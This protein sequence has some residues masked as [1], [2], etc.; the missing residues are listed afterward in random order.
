MVFCN[1]D[2][3]TC[4]TRRLHGPDSL[5]RTLSPNGPG[6]IAFYARDLSA[7]AFLAP[8]KHVAKKTW[9]D[10]PGPAGTATAFLAPIKHVAKKTWTDR[11]GPA[12]TI[13][14]FAWS[15][16]LRLCG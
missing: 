8:I 14:C 11:P 7:T 2:S 16:S 6:Q 12:G 5:I 1:S 3:K 9:T 15:S 4:P 10:R 13:G